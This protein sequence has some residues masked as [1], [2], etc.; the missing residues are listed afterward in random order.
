[1][2]AHADQ[3]L[4]QATPIPATGR[5]ALSPAE[6][7]K[8]VEELG[9]I[10][11]A[12]SDVTDRLQRSHDQLNQTVDSL[13]RELGE[14]DRQ[15]E[16][17]NRL[18]ALGEMAAGLA[19]E[20]RNPLGGIQLYAS[21]LARDLAGQEQPLQVVRKISG[22]VKH[23][24]SLVSQ[25]L[26]FTREIAVNLRPTELTDVVGQAVEFASKAMEDRRVRCFVSGE[27]SVV[28]NVD[29]LFMGQAVLNLLLNAAE[30]CEDGGCVS[31]RFESAKGAA[32]AKQF[33][34][35]VRDTGPGIP[36]QIMDRIFNPF[37]TTRDTGTGL[38]LAIVHRIVEAHDGTI[39]ARNADGGG[40]EFEIRV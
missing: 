4:G 34:I 33:R 11:L 8:R 18:A 39:V 29:P 3:P 21:M 2:I 38:G 24:E 20:I 7:A 36:V 17:R 30:A 32:D 23:L 35:T 27:E 25:V 37:F 40:A 19:H 5:P 31:L 28:V 10:I 14:K 6:L 15:L 22:G 26:N 16:R 9:R 13:R 1:M 12:Y